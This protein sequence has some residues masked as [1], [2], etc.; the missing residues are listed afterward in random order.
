MSPGI[1]DRRYSSHIGD[2]I[3]TSPRPL[4]PTLAPFVAPA[5][6]AAEFATSSGSIGSDWY[7]VIVGLDVGVFQ[8]L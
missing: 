6:F 1:L 8:Y 5:T 7:V 3:I 2:K 4:A